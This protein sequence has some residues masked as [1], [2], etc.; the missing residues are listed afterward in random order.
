M[1]NN[2]LK[3]LKANPLLLKNNLDE[4]NKIK[5]DFILKK[6]ADSEYYFI[7]LKLEEVKN[8]YKQRY[9]NS[10]IKV[11]EIIDDII[12]N[13]KGDYGQ[14]LLEYDIA[15]KL[16]DR[17]PIIKFV[18]NLNENNLK[19]NELNDSIKKWESLEKMFLDKKIKKMKKKEKTNLINYFKNPKNK[20]K[21]IEIYGEDIYEFIIKSEINIEKNKSINNNNLEEK[22]NK[23]EIKEKI[24]KYENIIK[25]DEKI[26][27][28]VYNKPLENKMN[29]IK[30]EFNEQFIDNS[31]PVPGI[32]NEKNKTYEQF[33]KESE[34]N[35][36]IQMS[37][38]MT[39]KSSNYNTEVKPEESIGNSTPL[40]PKELKNEIIYIMAKILKKSLISFKFDR[41]LGENLIFEEV[42]FGELNTKININKFKESLLIS[43][44][45][46]IAKKQNNIIYNYKK[47]SFFLKEIE[48][49]IKNEFDL[50]YPLKIKMT[51][52]SKNK[53]NNSE[54]NIS[55]KYTFFEPFTNKQ[56]NF[57]EDNILVNGT[58]SNYQGFQFMIFQIKN[59]CYENLE[60]KYN[61]RNIN[62]IEDND[63][64]ILK[65]ENIKKESLIDN[66]I[67]KNKFLNKKADEDKIIE[68]I[69]TI[70]RGNNFIGL[71]KELNNGNYISYKNN[72]TII[73]Y[74]TYFKR[75]KDQRFD[76]ITNITEITNYEDAKNKDISKIVITGY[77]EI[78]LMKID[79]KT[80][81]I[82][83]KNLNVSNI[84][85]INFFEIKKN[86]Y[87]ISGRNICM[88][89]LNLFNNNSNDLQK[90]VIESKS[91]FGGIKINENTIAL[92]SNNLK[93]GGEDKIIFYNAK[94][95]RILNEIEGYSHS[96]SP[97]GLAIIQIEKIIMKSESTQKSKKNRKKK[98]KNSN[99]AN[100][101]T[102]NERVLLCACKSYRKKEENGILLI[103]P[104]IQE[105]KNVEHYFYNTGN[106]EPYC[107]CQILIVEN[108]NKNL[109]NIDD[110]Y[111]KNI[112]IKETDYFLVGGLDAEKRRGAIKLYKVNFNEKSYI[113]KIEYLQD[114]ELNEKL[115]K[116]L[117]ED[118]NE[119]FDGPINC[120]IQSRISGNIL[121]TC[122]NGYIYLFSLP[123][124][125]FYLDEE[126]AEKDN[127]KLL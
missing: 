97:N 126:E 113:R 84:Y 95:K 42:Y 71:I 15:K 53:N 9:P 28:K 99:E 55:C 38:K 81:N 45:L 51:L 2:I 44:N 123:N 47:F 91:Y 26:D 50:D 101:K 27:K 60:E 70:E 62:A 119:F 74:D 18:Y 6:F 125:N 25:I 114:I 35:S 33:L 89:I 56:Y 14:Y 108:N 78:I 122:Y 112:K 32:N 92:T 12:K 120:I 31:A 19:E 11:I 24:E 20:K 111:K 10:K 67:E 98:N 57:I 49:R 77:K 29:E 76:S 93:E 22:E 115:N 100:E 68:L 73:L 69:E 8:Y 103:N 64:N 87:I 117:N 79:F 102:E 66:N 82:E 59:E 63:I 5:F 107:F 41:K 16:N 37:E 48:E 4:E 83:T 94:S 127:N 52:E 21:L 39:S 118:L 54:P 17:I 43:L 13:K 34:N 30:D 72:H 105:N 96:I 7:K 90:N 124:I 110:E 23:N 1:K 65:G 58:N 104:Q 36:I 109:D 40:F 88:H 75:I 116:K 106:F 61:N 85:S 80:L 121:V 46:N 3:L 86:N